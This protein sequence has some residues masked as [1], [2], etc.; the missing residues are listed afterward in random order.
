MGEGKV[1]AAITLTVAALVTFT[2]AA[3]SGMG[4]ERFTTTL[5]VMLIS[6][7]LM[8]F[9]LEDT[10]ERE[11]ESTKEY[12]AALSEYRA[13]RS[14]ITPEHIDPLRNFCLD[15]SRRELEYRRLCFLGERGYSL[16]QLQAY[17][18]GEKF[19]RRAARTFK[20]AESLRAIKLS[21]AMLMSA[22]HTP[23]SELRDP[24]GRKL[25]DA[26]TSLIPSTLA[27]VFTVSVIITAKD[28]MTLSTVLDGIVKLSALPI[29]GFKGMLDGFRFCRVDRS[30]WLSAKA[31]IIRGFLK[32][33]EGGDALGSDI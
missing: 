26:L 32:E 14:K 15:Y 2:D 21:P 16:S 9:S 17:R 3:L 25:L 19:P 27:T 4:A 24:R 6:S 20:R 13:A 7:Y 5:T 33:M 11:G 10:G 31:G 28:G 22:D 29:I 12:Q 30:A 8:Y 18:D 1:I 23:S